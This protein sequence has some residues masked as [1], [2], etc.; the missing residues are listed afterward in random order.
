MGTAVSD[1]GLCRLL[2]F[3]VPKLMSLFNC[4]CHNKG[5]VEARGNC[6]LFATRPVFTARSC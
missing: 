5:S 2:T 3:H 1:P 6:I 4:L